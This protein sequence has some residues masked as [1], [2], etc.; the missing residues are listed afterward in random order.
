MMITGYERKKVLGLVFTENG[1]ICVNC[2]IFTANILQK[3]D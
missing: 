3:S 1:S 2:S